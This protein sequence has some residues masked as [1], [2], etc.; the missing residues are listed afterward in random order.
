M[1][2][3]RNAAFSD[4]STTLTSSAVCVVEPAKEELQ[5]EIR[6]LRERIKGLE[7]DN[8]SMYLKLSKTQQDVD[9]RLSEIEMQIGPEDNAAAD[10]KVRGIEETREAS[11][12]SGSC[13]INSAEDSAEE[14]EEDEKNRESFI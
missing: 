1:F 3:H 8:T 14:E 11:V 12:A 4:P 7:G 9:Q 13:S 10:K 2:S 5:L 6:R